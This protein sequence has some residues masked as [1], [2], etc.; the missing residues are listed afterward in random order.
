LVEKIIDLGKLPKSA[1][2]LARK[3]PF[4]RMLNESAILA[5]LSEKPDFPP[6]R[7]TIE[8]FNPTLFLNGGQKSADLV[9]P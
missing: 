9:S 2:F 1:V 8:E 3:F 7:G 4:L 6:L 5:R